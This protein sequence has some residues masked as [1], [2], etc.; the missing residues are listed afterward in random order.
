MFER[1]V[2]WLNEKEN[3]LNLTAAITVPLLLLAMVLA[4]E[5]RG[6]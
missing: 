1:F 3:G 2:C 5:F 4:I 6:A